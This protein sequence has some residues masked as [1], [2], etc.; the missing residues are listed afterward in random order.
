MTTKIITVEATPPAESTGADYYKGAPLNAAEFDQNLVNLRA[1]V[2]RKASLSNPTFTGTVVLPATTSIGDVSATELQYLNSVT[3]NVQDQINS[4]PPINNP[5]FTGTVS[6]PGGTANGV[7]YLNGSKQVTSGSGLTFN[8]A[9]LTVSGTTNEATTITSNATTTALVLDNTHANGWG[10]NLAI[11]TGGVTAGFFGTVGSLLGST[12]QNLAIYATAGNGVCFYTN[13]STE[14]MT[15]DSPG[16]LGL[17]VPPSAWYSSH[18]AIQV[19]A[20]AA[21]SSYAGTSTNIS[22]NWYANTSGTDTYLTS[23]NAQLFQ[24]SSDGYKWFTAPSGTAGNAITFTQA[25]TLDANGRWLLGTTS[26]VGNDFTSIRF[27]SS[28]FYSQG[29]N[30]VDANAS[31]NGGIFMVFRRSDDTGL[32]SIKRSGTDTALA[33][34]GNSYLAFQ[35][36]STE[37]ARITS[38]G[39]LLVGTTSSDGAGGVSIVP[40][41]VGP[42]IMCKGPGTTSFYDALQIYSTGASDYR[43][44]V[45][46]DG[47]VHAVNTTISAISDIRY[48]E[49]IRDLDDGLATIMSLK[50]RKFDWKEGKGKNIKNDRGF[51]AQELE[52][53][54][55]ELI[56]TWKGEAP[57][58]EEPYKSVRQDLI[59]ILVKA[60]QE[61]QAIIESLNQRI[62]ALEYTKQGE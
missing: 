43:F 52:Q 38:S 9:K 2:D 4:K 1:A 26:G 13:G 48:K 34:D 61:Q 57:E 54:L 41:A 51:I 28:S 42:R 14:R 49:N 12:S 56:D 17:G 58:G 7:L 22:R 35:T 53:V 27:N 50:P 24:M 60:I 19:G 6:L 25:M 23:S 30:M 5:T 32:G 8:G 55:P 37:R 62:E 47:T 15:L 18:K 3:S 39:Y 20:V 45:G 11:K 44:F 33:I 40:S 46:Y 31:S 10:S 29:M 36:G 16:N 21:M 59:P